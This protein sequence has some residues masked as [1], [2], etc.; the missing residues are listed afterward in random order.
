MLLCRSRPVVHC[1][2]LLRDILSAGFPG[3]C[4]LPPE[5]L[6][7]FLCSCCW[8]F[9]LYKRDVYFECTAMSYFTSYTNSSSVFFYRGFYITKTK[10]KSFYIVDVPGRNAVES[11]EYFFLVLPAD[12]Y[13]V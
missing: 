9:L 13:A 8:D 3:F 2:L 7:F 1:S 6:K 4:R 12:T 10:A 5:E 11:I